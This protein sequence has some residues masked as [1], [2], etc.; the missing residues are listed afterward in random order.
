MSSMVNDSKFELLSTCGDARRGRLH[1]NGRTLETPHLFPVVVFYGGGT[2]DSVYGGG[3]HRTIKEFFLQEEVLDHG[4]SYDDI[5]NGVMTSVSSLGAFK[6]HNERFREY[7]E[8][9]IR[10]QEVFSNF[11]GVVFIDSGGY[12]ILNDWDGKIEGSDFELQIDQSEAFRLQ[13]QMGAD[14]IVNLDEPIHPDDSQKV[15]EQKTKKTASNIAEFAEISEGYEGARYV[16]VH[17]YGRSALH[18]CF[19]EIEEELGE[20]IKDVFDGV[21]LGSLVPVK[22]N[23]EI[24]TNSVLSC[25]QEMMERGLNSFPLHI[26]G[27]SRK[28]IPLL[29]AHGADTFDSGSYYT[30]AYN[31]KYNTSISRTVPISQADF[32]SCGCRVCRDEQMQQRMRGDAEFQK[33]VDG[34]IAIHNLIMQQR[35]LDEIRNRISQSSKQPLIDYI[36]GEFENMPGARKYAW[37]VIDQSLEEYF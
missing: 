36:I 5:F 26:L 9:A 30:Q 27:I 29:V 2:S 25:R 31:G 33:D 20:P 10:E 18:R 6:V 11:N 21:A 4:E 13:S 34:P 15:R 7:T 19:D 35:E 3:I 8:T 12:K 23:L 24:L 17:G 37:R 22:D 1:L 14:I 32:E 16:T 28:A